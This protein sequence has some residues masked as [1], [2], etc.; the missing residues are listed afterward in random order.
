PVRR[1]RRTSF[2]RFFR[3]SATFARLPDERLSTRTRSASAPRASPRWLPKNPAPPVIT[4]FGRAIAR[5]RR[6][7][8]AEGK[9]VATRLSRRDAGGPVGRPAA[10]FE[11]WREVAPGYARRPPADT[12][13]E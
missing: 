2:A 1:S 8:G 13:A 6:P 4:T 5:P 12:D 11:P 9:K 7:K 10:R 3:A